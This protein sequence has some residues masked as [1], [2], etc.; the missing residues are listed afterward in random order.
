MPAAAAPPA[1]WVKLADV[2]HAEVVVGGRKLEPFTQA[3][4]QSGLRFHMVPI[5]GG[6]YMMGSP[7]DE[8]GREEI[9]G[10]RQQVAVKPF[11]MGAFEVSWEE[12]DEF[13][14]RY[15]VKRAE[16]AAAAG[17]PLPRTALDE[18][19]DAMTR[20]TPPYVDMSFGYGRAGNP[21]ICMTQK[22]AAQ[23]CAWLS[24]KTGKRYRLP[25]EA[26]WEWA[27]RAG[28]TTPYFFGDAAK[29]DEYA[30]Y[31]DNSGEKPQPSGRRKPSPWGL[32]DIHGNVC[33]WVQDT[34]E[35]DYFEILAGRTEAKGAPL[36]EPVVRD[37]DN[38]FHAVR[39]GSW[40]D[41]PEF[42]RSA[43][44][45]GEDDDW[46]IQDPQEP[47]SVWWETDA[48]WV[49]FRVVCDIDDDGTIAAD[50]PAKPVDSTKAAG[51]V[52]QSAEAADPSEGGSE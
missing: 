3:I 27:C 30:V 51:A 2:P 22:A 42:L 16:E 43:A 33:E 35:Q 4:G 41:D 18:K 9:E 17:T 40:Q 8:E 38:A 39:G 37:P 15:D 50:P 31:Y 19:A 48:H 28:T 26:E 36:L 32:Y 1:E 47:K 21:A 6:T 20:P 29:L 10:P 13:T 44:R 11:Y 25:T 12:F 49:G 34:W 23:Y 45:Y 14:F 7:E 46:K 52:E 5:P 24:A